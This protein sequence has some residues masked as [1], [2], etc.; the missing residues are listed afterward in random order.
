MMVDPRDPPYKAA[1]ANGWIRGVTP[2]SAREIDK[3]FV[4]QMVVGELLEADTVGNEK[5][6][7]K[8][9]YVVERNNSVVQLVV[10]VV[11]SE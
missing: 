1:S 3:H 9:M 8:I 7:H 4:E 6:L 2:S 11:D 10:T 5:V